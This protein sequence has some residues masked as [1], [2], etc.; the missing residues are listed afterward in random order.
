MDP[1]NRGYALVDP[2]D[3]GYTLIPWTLL[4]GVR[5][6]TLINIKPIV[7]VLTSPLDISVA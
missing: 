7:S 2:I 4:V 3:E 6:G 1:I 5:V